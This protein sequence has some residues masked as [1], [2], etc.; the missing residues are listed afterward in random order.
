L[1]R[2]EWRI[3]EADA[4]YYPDAFTGTNVTTSEHVQSSFPSFKI[5]NAGPKR[6]FVSYQ[7]DMVG[8]M[9][10]KVGAWVADT[11]GTS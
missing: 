1:D 7:N 10:T 2:Y 3:R 4:Q 8:G 11:K 5:E 9:G 6:G